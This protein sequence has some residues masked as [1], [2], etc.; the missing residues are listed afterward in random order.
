MNDYAVAKCSFD[1]EFDVIGPLMTRSVEARH[2][3]EDLLGLLVNGKPALPGTLI[4]GVLRSALLEISHVLG[5]AY[6]QEQE[7]L[8]ALLRTCFGPPASTSDQS[9]A[10]Q[11]DE[12]AEWEPDRGAL[13]FS[14]YWIADVKDS[15]QTISRIKIDPVT[16]SVKPGALVVAR[17][18]LGIGQK[19]TFKGDVQAWLP[20]AEVNMLLRWFH[21]AK[22][23][24]G[25]VGGATTVG[26][27]R[28]VEVRI[29]EPDFQRIST[30]AI[31]WQAE[32]FGFSLQPDRPFC[33][34]RP[35]GRGNVLVSQ[36]TIPGGAII[37]AVAEALD[38]QK[39]PDDEWGLL[40]RNLHAVH[41]TH[42]HPSQ[43]GS[44]DKSKAFRQN[45]LPLSIA[46]SPG[47]APMDVSR[48]A[49]M[50]DIE[51]VYSS[52]WKDFQRQ[53]VEA[54]LGHFE[55]VQLPR[56]TIV[57][58]AIDLETGASSD[59]ALFAYD[60]IDPA[61]HEWRFNVRIDS[62]KLDLGTKA[63]EVLAQFR[64]WLSIGLIGLGK[65]K[66]RAVVDDRDQP[67]AQAFVD[68]DFSIEQQV[69]V[70]S[71]I[72]IL[73]VTDADLLGAVDRLHSTGGEQALK[74]LYQRY[75]NRAFGQGLLMLEDWFTN[76]A[77]AGGR[78]IHRRFWCREEVVD[79][80]PH[81]MTSAGSVFRLR[82]AKDLNED[83]L[84]ELR[85]RIERA[86]RFG[87]TPGPVLMENSE[88]DAGPVASQWQ[89]HP[90]LSS[91]GYGEILLQPK[92]GLEAQSGI[93][94]E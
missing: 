28:V 92:L 53:Q 90:W 75:F 38:R 84:R 51:V 85:R 8:D 15:Q 81:V 20:R 18:P 73:L 52:D 87:L 40:R 65:T 10:S 62:E 29:S 31:S 6:Q 89:R 56:V 50:D 63:A 46:W 76:E 27:G 54:A 39:S 49:P 33:F 42:G 23:L 9:R 34:A 26:F 47:Q 61:E 57:R 83:Q 55:P 13:N 17:S 16:G 71:A 69:G 2:F 3:S 79:Y 64:A 22:P 48:K 19:A 80:R 58:N 93:S 88:E 91:Q 36:S 70:G 7:E 43:K 24:V 12:L 86:R 25:A 44:T 1:I 72:T 94:H 68:P 60:A 35:H 77:L 11:D 45:P 5:P 82:V 67:W 37:G 66:A 78:Y 74:E 32:E 41:V 21:K 30:P 4:K 59:S 14:S